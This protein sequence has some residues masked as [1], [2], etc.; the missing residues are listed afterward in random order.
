MKGQREELGGDQNPSPEAPPM[1][2][3]RQEKRERKGCQVRSDCRRN[4]EE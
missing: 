3:K 1:S 2:R 4:D